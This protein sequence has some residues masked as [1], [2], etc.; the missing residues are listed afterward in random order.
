MIWT[1]KNVFVDFSKA[2][3]DIFSCSSRSNIPLKYHLFIYME[4][5]KINIGAWVPLTMEGNIM[6]DGILASCYA[7]TDHDS[8][9]MA[10]MSIRWFPKIV[11]WIYGEENGSSVF[12]QTAKQFGKSVN[13][14][15]FEARSF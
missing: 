7:S 9:H 8:A 1:Y 12:S 3:T 14:Q 4:I 11:D 6:V 5:L 13:R 2:V 10:M 15:L